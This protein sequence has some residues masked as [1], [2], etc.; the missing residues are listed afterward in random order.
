MESS[1]VPSIWQPVAINEPLTSAFSPY[2]V[3]ACDLSLVNIFLSD[4]NI[5]L[6]TSS[7]KNSLLAS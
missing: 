5:S 4:L 3:G 1:T 6:D 2:I 7:V